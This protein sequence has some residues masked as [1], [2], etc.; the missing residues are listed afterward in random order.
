ML[1]FVPRSQVEQDLS[2]LRTDISDKQN[3]WNIERVEIT[4]EREMLSQQFSS[5]QSQVSDL[6]LELSQ[7][8]WEGETEGGEREG[9]ITHLL[10]M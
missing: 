7:V 1:V 3:T 5:E 10:S 6:K 2:S 8:R 4:K 9:G